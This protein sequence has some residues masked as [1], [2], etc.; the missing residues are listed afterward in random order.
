MP[1]IKLFRL[2]Q[3]SGSE[4]SLRSANI[5]RLSFFDVRIH[6]VYDFFV[7][8]CF[9]A[10]VLVSTERLNEPKNLHGYR[11]QRKSFC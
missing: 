5:T 3:V 4:E 8:T 9:I 11:Y 7:Q 6:T 10:I 2:F 1:I